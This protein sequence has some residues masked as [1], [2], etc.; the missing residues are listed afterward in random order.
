M[1]I[2]RS[3]NTFVGKGM[4]SNMLPSSK[5]VS[6]YSHNHHQKTLSGGKY[7]FQETVPLQVCNNQNS[8][9][10]KLTLW[11]NKCRD[12]RD[13]QVSHGIKMIPMHC[14][15]FN[16]AWR[17]TKIHSCRGSTIIIM[18]HKTL[19]FSVDLGS[20]TKF[21]RLLFSQPI[22]FNSK[23]LMISTNSP[24]LKFMPHKINLWILMRISQ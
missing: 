10:K 17:K 14:T 5:K 12:P 15:I 6:N 2:R 18:S 7:Q 23:N 3:D 13:I 1:A 16:K 8:P 9:H 19:T 22:T 21:S 24:L 4:L 11:N 20:W